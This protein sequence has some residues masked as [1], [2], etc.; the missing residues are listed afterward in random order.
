[1]KI[2]V[3]IFMLI[4]IIAWSGHISKVFS[5]GDSISEESRLWSDLKGDL[6]SNFDEAASKS[7]DAAQEAANQLVEAKGDILADDLIKAT[8]DIKRKEENTASS[9]EGDA[10]CPIYID[11][12]PK[13]GEAPVCQIPAGCEGITQIAY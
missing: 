5:R 2:G 9:T 7:E 8:E 1:M 13:I 12:M 4:V 6:L 10:A 11:C 3:A